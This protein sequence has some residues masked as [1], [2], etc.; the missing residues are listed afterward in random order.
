MIAGCI[1]VIVIIIPM[2][3]VISGKPIVAI[4]LNARTFLQVGL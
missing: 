4:A 3:A 1:P 2:Q